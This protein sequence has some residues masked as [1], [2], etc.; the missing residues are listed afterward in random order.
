MKGLRLASIRATLRKK[1]YKKSKA[2]ESVERTVS[3]NEDTS[4]VVCEGRD[5]DNEALIIAREG[6]PNPRDGADG[7]REAVED[8]R[9]SDMNVHEIKSAANSPVDRKRN[10]TSIRG[11]VKKLM[12]PIFR[13][14]GLRKRKVDSREKSEY[15]P[16]FAVMQEDLEENSADI[17][18]LLGNFHP[19]STTD[20]ETNLCEVDEVKSSE[21][22]DEATSDQDG[23]K[24][25]L[26]VP[27]IELS[28]SATW[29]S[30]LALFM[31][32]I[33]LETKQVTVS[34]DESVD[35]GIIEV[36]S[37]DGSNDMA[38][39]DKEGA[40]TESVVGVE[41]NKYVGKIQQ[42]AP[43]PFMKTTEVSSESAKDN[44]NIQPG[45]FEVGSEDADLAV[46]DMVSSN[47]EEAKGN[48]SG[49]AG[50][51]K[52]KS[53][54]GNDCSLPASSWV[55]A[56]VLYQGKTKTEEVPSVTAQEESAGV[57]RE[58]GDGVEEERNVTSPNIEIETRNCEADLDNPQAGTSWSPIAS[59]LGRETSDKNF[60]TDEMTSSITSND[61]DQ[62]FCQMTTLFYSFSNKNNE[63]TEVDTRKE[64]LSPEILS[65]PEDGLPDQTTSIAEPS[66]LKTTD[67]SKNLLDQASALLKSPPS[68]SKEIQ[69]RTTPTTPTKATKD[70]S[71][72]KSP[73]TS[74]EKTTTPKP[75]M[76][77]TKDDSAF[78]SRSNSAKKTLATPSQRKIRS[79]PTQVNKKRLFKNRFKMELVSKKLDRQKTS[80]TVPI[81]K[82]SKIKD[83]KITSKVLVN[84]EHLFQPREIPF[85]RTVSDTEVLALKHDDDEICEAY[86]LVK[87]S[88]WNGVEH[89]FQDSKDEADSSSV[90]THI[91]GIDQDGPFVG[92]SKCGLSESLHETLLYWGEIFC[93]FIYHL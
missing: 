48:G 45:I 1:L 4:I 38:S 51:E 49:E 55:T 30:Q 78:K 14:A 20:G 53:D 84:I 71:A 63:A 67:S 3:N 54:A 64:A 39:H 93:K 75:P 9:N 44:S 36:R 69:V 91:S 59:C 81:Q 15:E 56:L 16:A 19:T 28:L 7:R 21:G 80:E 26:D 47:E 65:P 52:I 31:G 66:L 90:V 33:Q 79:K 72:F 83:S 34:N 8:T 76:K 85:E 13:V 87:P 73:S 50:V 89:Q 74:A 77:A 82:E 92:S 62:A 43:V 37:E 70:N 61:I 12:S 40:N 17:D 86:E 6:E 2:G 25:E 11:K 60:E 24:D 22:V 10:R 32:A 23:T 41:R 27:E 46:S 35:C 58:N 88:T 68:C 5:D 18:E 42:S 29:A 57:I